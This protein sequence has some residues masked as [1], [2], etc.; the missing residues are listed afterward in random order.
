[1]ALLKKYQDAHG[2]NLVIHGADT[3]GRT[4]TERLVDSG[5]LKMVIKGGISHAI[6]E[7]RE[8]R[9]S[10]MCRIGT[11]LLNI[12]IASSEITG[13]CHRSCRCISTAARAWCLSS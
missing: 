8:T 5:Y 7:A 4:H 10:G 13:A 12:L 2:E 1:M 3:L 9:Q 11:S 6:R